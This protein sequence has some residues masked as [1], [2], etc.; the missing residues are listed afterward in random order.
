MQ[1]P[2]AGEIV[3]KGKSNPS[4]IVQLDA[5]RGLAAM[6]VVLFH[7]TTKFRE[8]Y[9]PSAE[10][11][12]E[13]SWGHYGVNLFFIISGFVI[14]MTLS[15][16]RDWRDFVVSRF[17]RLY[18]A[19]WFAVALTFTVVAWL[20]LPGKEVGLSD[21]VLNL[22]MFQTWLKVP[23]VDGVYWTLLVELHFYV[24]ALLLFLYNQMQ[25]WVRWIWLL[26]LLRL[27]YR[28][29]S[30]FLGIDLPYIVQFALILDYIPW[31]AL[32]ISVYFLVERTNY[33]RR[34]VWITV[35]GA[36]ALLLL[37]GGL[38][39]L[40]IAM[41]CFAAVLLAARGRLVGS[42]G[43]ILVWLGA[44]SYT[45]YLLHEHIGWA[46]MRQ[47]SIAGYDYTTFMPLV[48]LLVLALA[49]ATTVFVERPSMSWIR[50]RYKTGRR[51]SVS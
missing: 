13:V 6:A 37:S 20:G 33:D 50:S 10:L 32:G 45:L 3:V 43:P 12:F 21:A 35:L 40:L 9:A 31:F 18:P 30:H 22:L 23:S 38:K 39:L 29:S 27:A 17:S 36:L 19:Y 28:L 4:R 49:W 34:S 8:L 15:R 41:A 51:R 1:D 26:F 5:L 24:L 14:F 47:M 25:Q 2:M 42:G 16:S 48:L 44:I 7:F 11:P 46:V